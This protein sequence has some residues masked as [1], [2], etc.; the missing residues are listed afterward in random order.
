MHGRKSLI[1]AFEIH[2]VWRPKKRYASSSLVASELCSYSGIHSVDKVSVISY[3]VARNSTMTC[4]TTKPETL[5]M[6]TVP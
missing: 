1:L 2:I 5:M 6:T 4:L 3:N